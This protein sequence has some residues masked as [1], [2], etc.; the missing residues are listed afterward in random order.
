[1]QSVETVG[2]SETTTGT[3]ETSQTPSCRAL[4]GRQILQLHKVS[5]FY[6]Y[7]LSIYI[8]Y[9]VSI[10]VPWPPSIQLEETQREFLFWKS[11]SLNPPQIR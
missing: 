3:T 5:A 9:L 2:N 4:A 10:K 8:L 1:M 6:I 7:Y 11:M